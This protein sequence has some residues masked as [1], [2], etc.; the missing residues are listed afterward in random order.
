[1]GL[2]NIIVVGVIF[3]G[4]IFGVWEFLEIICGFLF[5]IVIVINNKNINRKINIENMVFF[6]LLISVLIVVVF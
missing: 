1:M 5:V 6:C 3:I 4:F 2:V